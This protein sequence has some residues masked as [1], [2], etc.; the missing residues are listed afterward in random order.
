MCII[1]IKPIGCEV[2]TNAH[3]E[4]SWDS[5]PDGAGLMIW[6]HGSKHVEIHKGFMKLKHFKK[7]IKNANIQP[8]DI[9]VYHLRIATHGKI[10]QICTH[11]FPL[12]NKIEDM[13]ALHGACKLGIAHNGI[14]SGLKTTDDCS[15]SMAFI[16]ETLSKLSP[17]MIMD[18]A[19]IL[20]IMDHIGSRF[21]FLVPG[22]L[23]MTGDGWIHD[24]STGL[25]FS[26]SSYK[27]VSWSRGAYGHGLSD[28]WEKWSRKQSCNF[29]WD[30]SD[31]N[32]DLEDNLNSDDALTV[33]CPNCA[34]IDA[35]IVEDMGYGYVYCND[36]N[37]YSE[38]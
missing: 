24:D 16:I 22:R 34:S 20:G 18:N 17:E 36:C 28:Y 8:N 11:P 25:Y 7:A 13:H 30:N 26:N 10:S 12:S 6:R 19:G 1:I 29:S 4:N 33:E 23:A 14:I 35:E 21:A 2:P 31:D 9:A 38:I 15:D 32:D 3:I 5:N 37:T 27:S